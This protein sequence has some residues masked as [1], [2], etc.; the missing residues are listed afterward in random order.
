MV[1]ESALKALIFDLDGVLVDTVRLHYR[2]SFNPSAGFI[3]TARKLSEPDSYR[4][5]TDL[6]LRLGKDLSIIDA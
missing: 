1:S 2:A 6:L 5:D 3:Q 4:I